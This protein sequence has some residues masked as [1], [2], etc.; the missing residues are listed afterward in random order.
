MPARADLNAVVELVQRWSGYRL[1]R[2]ASRRQATRQRQARWRWS[3][4]TAPSINTSQCRRVCSNRCWQRSRKGRSSASES[5]R[6]THIDVLRVERSD[7]WPRTLRFWRWQAG[8]RGS[9]QAIWRAMANRMVMKESSKWRSGRAGERTVSL[10]PSGRREK[11]PRALGDDEC[12]ATESNR[13]VV[14]P[15]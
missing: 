11:T 13:D 12:I 10:R 3:I 1:R 9:Q 6:A 2:R 5:E 4:A 8:Q 14:M 7:G 15:A